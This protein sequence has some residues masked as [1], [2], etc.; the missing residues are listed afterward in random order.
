MKYSNFWGLFQNSLEIRGGGGWRY[1]CKK[2][3]YVLTLDGS[4]FRINQV[5]YSIVSTFV[6]I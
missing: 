3:G 6:D 1:S 4:G 5:H 2:T